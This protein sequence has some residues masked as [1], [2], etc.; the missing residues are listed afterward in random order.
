MNALKNFLSEESGQTAVEYAVLL[1]MIA[2]TCIITIR[3]LGDISVGMWANN[4]TK[5]EDAGF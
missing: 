3:A 2:M 1:A 4:Q 5:L